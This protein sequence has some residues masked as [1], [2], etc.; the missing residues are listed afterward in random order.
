[1]KP[2]FLVSVAITLGTSVFCCSNVATAAQAPN[3]ASLQGAWLEQS[4]KCQEVYV[5][6][7]NGMAFR[8]NVN[9]F[10][11]AIL[12]S[13]TRLATPGA[14][15]QIRSL[16]GAKDRQ[17]MLLS[18]ATSITHTPITAYISFRDGALY[19][20]TDESDQVGSRYD[21]CLPQQ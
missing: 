17:T 2:A 21:R 6:K 5:P 13:G 1:M 7:R 12:I 4:M 19:R 8:K 10:A 14:I 16:S 3:L 20:F 11:P 9:L 15:C 18:C